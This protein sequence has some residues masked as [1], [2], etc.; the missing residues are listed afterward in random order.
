[1][2]DSRTSRERLDALLAGL[3]DEILR[4]DRTGRRLAEEGGGAE[5]VGAMRSGIESLIQARRNGSPRQAVLLS[6]AGE[7]APGAKAMVTQ[8][9]ARLGRWAG[10]VQGAR[11]GGG[12]PRVRMAFSGKP[13]EEGGKT[14]RKAR[15]RRGGGSDGAKHNKC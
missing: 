11:V 14:A 1:M 8:A 12:T 10:V 9:M 15:R 6:S 4:S 2:T 7:G 13:T 5:D 3:E